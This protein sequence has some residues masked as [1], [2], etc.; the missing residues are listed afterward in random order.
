M[1][2]S[3]EFGKLADGAAPADAARR[4]ANILR[5]AS[6]GAVAAVLTAG[7]TAHAD[8]ASCTALS[9]KTY[10]AHLMQF[11]N[12][13]AKITSAVW[14]PAAGALPTYCKVRGEISPVDPA[15]TR[16]LFAFNLPEVWNKKAVQAGGGGLNGTLVE[17]IGLLRDDPPGGQPLAKGYVTLGTDGGHPNLQPEQ[18]VFHLNSEAEINNAYGSNKNAHDLSRVVIR[19]Y[20][21]EPPRR[22]YF[23]GGSE[24]GRQALVAAQMFPASYDGIVSNVPS[25]NKTMQYIAKNALWA[26]TM[27]GGWMNAA[28]IKL[29]ADTTM[30][31]CDELDGLKDGVISRYRGCNSVYK[32][33]RIRCPN[34]ANTG[35]NCLS[36][37]QI[38]AVGRV[39]GRFTMPYPLRFGVS[40]LAG[41][42]TGGE[43]QP[44]GY[45]DQIMDETEPKP[46]DLGSHLSGNQ[47]VRYAIMQD[48]NAR[49]APD[50]EKYRTRIVE[51]SSIADMS[52]PDMSLFMSRGGKIIMKANGAD[53]QVGPESVFDYYENVVRSMGKAATDSFIRVYANPGAAHNGSGLRADGSKIP[54]KVD[55]LGALDAW[56]ER[57]EAPDHLTVTAYNGQTPVATKPLCLYPNYP[58]YKGSGDPNQ[59]ASYSCTPL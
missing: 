45:I 4:R 43:T 32:I 9:G 21:K 11:P 34:G 14:T 56:V 16:T 31:A 3:G 52:D 19:E 25:L 37:A 15:A 29:L 42:A 44:G 27:G 18:A 57:G 17:A 30:A 24:G 5:F 46:G 55:L 54:D 35:D 6:A 12:T 58:R 10:P 40:S 20:Y 33:D 39:R 23:Y 49:G 48:P 8:E 7:G 26:S 22:F 41:W 51:L 38:A 59:A 28:E 13:G 36:D 47:F 1:K 53:Y 2:L 50:Y